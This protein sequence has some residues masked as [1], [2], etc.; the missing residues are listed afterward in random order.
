MLHEHEHEHEVAVQTTNQPGNC[1]PS[2]GTYRSGA[3]IFL[4][5]GFKHACY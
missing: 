4:L 2:P 3:M 5:L 1:S